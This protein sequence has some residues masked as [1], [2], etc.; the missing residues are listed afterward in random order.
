MK[1]IRLITLLLFPM[2]NSMAA[3]TDV[4]DSLLRSIRQQR[5]DTNC[6]QTMI[7]LS[8]RYIRLYKFDEGIALCKQIIVLADSLKN[9]RGKI[10]SYNNLGSLYWN[11]GLFQEASRS[12]LEGLKISEKTGF[13]R[14]IGRAYHGLGVIQNHLKND[15]KALEYF[16]KALENY[17]KIGEKAGEAGIY[18]NMGLIYQQTNNFP[19]AL[20]YFKKSLDLKIEMKDLNGQASTYNNLGI[21]YD[22][23]GENMK[24]LEHYQKS[25]A[26]RLSLG[27][28]DV[29]SG[30]YANLGSLH[31][32]M[33]NFSEA[34]KYLEKSKRIAIR[35]GNRFEAMSAFQAQAQLDSALGNMKSAYESYKIYIRYRDSIINDENTEKVIQQSVQ[36]DQDKKKA[37]DSLTQLVKDRQVALQRQQELQ[38]Q[39]LYTLAG[40]IGFTLMLAASL[41]SFRAYRQKQ[42]DNRVLSEQKALVEEKQKEIL[43]SIHYAKRIQQVLLPKERTLERILNKY[44]R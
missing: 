7:V 10:V 39:N 16:T 41:V 24:A 31:L 35:T 29:V 23:T 43:D 27:Q 44:L 15:A 33:K 6:M 25:V 42:K 11:K 32:K 34:G 18:N 1:K 8:Q 26:I 22:L 2:L 40:G 14:G 37:A 3:D 4:V 28:E 30:V 19:K 17:R 36:Y 5:R 12:Y 20:E 9:D 38:E 13:T 21:V